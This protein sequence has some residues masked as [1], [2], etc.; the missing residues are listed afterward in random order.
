MNNRLA[1]MLLFVL[2]ALAFAGCSSSIASTP[3]V[4]ASPTLRGA[5]EVT[6]VLSDSAIQA[7]QTTFA[8]GVRVPPR[9][10]YNHAGSCF[11][12]LVG[13]EHAHQFRW[14]IIDGR[15][16]DEHIVAFAYADPQRI[17]LYRFNWLTIRVRDGHT[18]SLQSNVLDGG[19]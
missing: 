12:H 9:G 16:G 13:Q 5:L 10:R 1:G 7:S 17:S 6:I 8:L 15:R 11:Q 19:A 4:A 18:M 2:L 3:K 14:L